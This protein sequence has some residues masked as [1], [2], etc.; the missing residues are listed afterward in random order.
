MFRE[1]ASF[2]GEKFP[3]RRPTAKLEDHSLLAVRDCLF[4]I[5]AA[6]LHIGGHSS[7]I[8]TVLRDLLR[9]WHCYTGDLCNGD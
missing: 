2:Y 8:L 3:A 9:K 4:N 5:F 7:M 1:Y 6:T